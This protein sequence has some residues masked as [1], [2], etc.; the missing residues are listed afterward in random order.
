LDAIF[1]AFFLGLLVAELRRS[2]AGMVAVAGAAIALALTP[3]APAGVPI[4]A[5]AL[6]VL[7][8]GRLRRRA[9]V[10][11]VTPAARSSPDQRR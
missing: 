1:P 6:A 3:V 10:A 8:P 7:V 11:A 4:I 5:A 9:P 2:R